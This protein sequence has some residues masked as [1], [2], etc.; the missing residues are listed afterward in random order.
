SQ[1]EIEKLLQSANRQPSG[2]APGSSGGTAANSADDASRP[3]SQDEIEKLLQQAG[4]TPATPPPA[5]KAAPSAGATAESTEAQ[6]HPADLDYLFRQAEQAL[7]SLESDQAGNLPPGLSPFEFTE[8]S[9]APPSTQAATLDLLKEV[10]LDVQIEL[11]RTRL[12]LEDVLRLRKG[13]VVTLDKLAGDPVDIYVN[14]RLI[15]RGEVLVLNDNFCI[16]VAELVAGKQPQI[17]AES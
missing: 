3:L 14:G 17:D 4:R 7:A 12:Y 11:G 9:G 15:A 10:E 1:E 6:I 5:A 16:R 13:A 8:F 2:G